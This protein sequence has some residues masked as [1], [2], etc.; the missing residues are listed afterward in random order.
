MATAAG[1]EEGV[2]K[3]A[4]EEEKG[5]EEELGSEEKNDREGVLKW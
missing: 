2:T 1:S 5:A 4:E 3:L